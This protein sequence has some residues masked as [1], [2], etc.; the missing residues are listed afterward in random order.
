[1]GQDQFDERH[2]CCRQSVFHGDML[3]CLVEHTLVTRTGE[4]PITVG[5]DAAADESLQWCAL[6]SVVPDRAGL[7]AG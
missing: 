1:M 6:I 5:D 4:D 3:Q 7:F 2:R